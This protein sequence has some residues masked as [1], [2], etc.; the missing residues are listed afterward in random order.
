M[1]ISVEKFDG[2]SSS[3]ICS[4]GNGNFESSLDLLIFGWFCLVCV[5]RIFPFPDCKISFL[6]AHYGC[7]MCKTLLIWKIRTCI[8][9]NVTTCRNGGIHRLSGP[10]E[11]SWCNSWCAG[12]WPW[13]KPSIPVKWQ[14]KPTKSSRKST[15]GKNDG[16]LTQSPEPYRSMLST[17]LLRSGKLG[18]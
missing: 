2:E 7:Q 1:H 4:K 17:S 13:R 10:N 14:Q 3:T 18:E 8:S 15:L 11:V 12:C 9:Q 6:V 5:L 16:C